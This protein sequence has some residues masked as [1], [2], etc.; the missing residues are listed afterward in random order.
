MRTTDQ[1][2]RLSPF[3]K[4]VYATGDLTVNTAL[5]ALS[6]VYASYYLIEVAGLRPALAG[7]IPLIG[8]IVDAVTD[9]LMG[10]L[11]DVTRWR[12]GRRRPYFLIGAVPFGMGFAMLW[13][14]PAL[15]SQSALFAYFAVTYSLFVCA[16][17]VLSVPY[18]ALLPE[19]SLDYDERTSF[20]TYRNAAS[21]LGIAVAVAMRPLAG[22]LGGGAA[23]FAATGTLL[24]A[25]MAL[26]WLAVHRVSFERPNF[27]LRPVRS[28]L[29]S[30]LRSLAAHRSFR[31]LVGFYLCGRVAMDV[32]GAML[33]VYLTHWI[34]RSEAFE[35]VMLLFLAA[36]VGSLPLWLRLSRE[37]E[38][39]QVFI[40]GAV[41]W[42]LSLALLG[43][44]R[45]D[46]PEWTVFVFAP[47]AGIGFSAVD[48]MPWSMVGDVTDE[49]DLASGERR[50]GLYNGVF[51]FLRKLAGAVAVALTLAVLDLA[52]LEAGQP[53]GP[54][55]VL[56]IRLLASVLPILCLVAAVGFARRYR[57][58][59]ADHASIL[60]SLRLREL[61]SAG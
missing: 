34:G 46:W 50:E 56:V 28:S 49:G 29:T 54:T 61:R 43:L 47:L 19:M 36:V 1:S 27:R 33:I 38:K 20:N 3:L 53:A 16:M 30:G 13:H 48:L 9:P 60:E 17:T 11:S 6:L 4:T 23:G 7:L 22:A 37:I 14:V 41:W 42:M 57:L 12:W 52:G 8:R 35:P 18:L 31:T 5:A 39:S 40:I 58:S 24:G 55:T 25:G 10:R 15:E 26:P 44:A 2:G 59:R 45:P 32:M 51:T 21:V